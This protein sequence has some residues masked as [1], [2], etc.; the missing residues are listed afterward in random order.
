MVLRKAMVAAPLHAVTVKAARGVMAVAAGPHAMDALS[1]PHAVANAAL[2][3][4]T[5]HT[6]LRLQWSWTLRYWK[7]APADRAVKST[8]ANIAA[9]AI[10]ARAVSAATGP[11]VPVM[12]G[13]IVLSVAIVRSVRTGPNVSCAKRPSSV[14][15]RASNLPTANPLP[16]PFR[17]SAPR[18]AQLRD[19]QA[20]RPQPVALRKMFPRS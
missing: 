10:A 14:R 20:C 16:G 12:S 15:S 8:P 2:K 1:G 5:R 11:I 9:D 17:I 7:H 6:A 18:S 13:P 4:A 3:V 19:R